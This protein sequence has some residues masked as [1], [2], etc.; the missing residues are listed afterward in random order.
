MMDPING[1]VAFLLNLF[2]YEGI[3]FLNTVWEHPDNLPKLE[4]IKNPNLW[5]SRIKKLKNEY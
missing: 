3:D 4:E 1:F 2:N 5:I